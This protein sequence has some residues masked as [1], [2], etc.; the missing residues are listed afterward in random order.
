[1][2]AILGRRILEE[3]LDFAVPGT[4]AIMVNILGGAQADSHLLA[5]QK[6]DLIPG[7]RIH[8]YGK[9]DARPGRKMGHVTVMAGSMGDAENRIG[10]LV[11][12]VNQLRADRRNPSSKKNT[13]PKGEAQHKDAEAN[14]VGISPLVAVTMGSDSDRSVLTPGIALLKELK[15][16]H[17]VTITSAHRTPQWMVRFAEDAA[18]NGIKVIIAAAGGAAHLPGMVAANTWLPVIGVPVKASV[19]DGLDSLLSIVQMPVCFMGSDSYEW[20]LVERSSANCMQRGCPVASVA[21]NNSVNAAQLAVRIL[22]VSHADIRERLQSH[23]AAQT[24]SVLEKAQ[25]MEIDGF[26]AY[27]AES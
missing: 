12:F 21:I 7:A 5:D 9:G 27:D 13:L 3:S 17:S 15:V 19:L 1:L 11:N 6:A 4:N 18:S 23:L 26:D 16:P 22:S 24:N 14:T 2:K 10:P 8:W 25:K 20:L